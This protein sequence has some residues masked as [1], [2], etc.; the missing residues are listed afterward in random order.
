MLKEEDLIQEV[1]NG[2]QLIA[3]AYTSP[4]LLTQSVN[5]VNQI[6]DRILFNLGQMSAEKISA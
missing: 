5:R 3:D 2:K 6:C 1:Q 4:A